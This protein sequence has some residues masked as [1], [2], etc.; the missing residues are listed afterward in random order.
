VPGVKECLK[1][2]DLLSEIDRLRE[3]ES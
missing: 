2:R 3:N 1:A